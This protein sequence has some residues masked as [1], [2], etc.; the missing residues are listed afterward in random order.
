MS[1][2]QPPLTERELLEEHLDRIRGANKEL[3]CRRRRSKTQL[4]SWPLI[5]VSVLV[6]I[7]GW[8]IGV[9]Y[10]SKDDPADRRTGMRCLVYATLAFVLGY[11]LFEFVLIVSVSS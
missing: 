4:P 5:L 2:P 10:V 1:D 6:P 9:I 11:V 3:P 7:L 8:I